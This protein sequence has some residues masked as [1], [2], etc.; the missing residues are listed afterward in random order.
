M[1]G[2]ASFGGCVGAAVADTDGRNAPAQDPAPGDRWTE[3]WRLRACD[4]FVEIAITFSVRP[5]G[6]I[7]IEAE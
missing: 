3:R 1:T 2:A 6:G 5:E 4:E 7:G